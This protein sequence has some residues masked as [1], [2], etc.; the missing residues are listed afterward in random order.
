MKKMQGED[1]EERDEM[2][3]EIIYSKKTTLF[4]HFLVLAS[5]LERYRYGNW[6]LGT[7]N[8]IDTIKVRE[9]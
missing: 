8:G 6:K 9:R 2:G 7:Y 3:D 4:S 1:A 5:L